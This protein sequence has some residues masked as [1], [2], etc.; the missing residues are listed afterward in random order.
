M[1]IRQNSFQKIP[2][3]RL[4]RSTNLSERIN[5]F[6]TNTPEGVPFIRRLLISES[7][8]LLTRADKHYK[9]SLSK[10]SKPPVLEKA[11]IIDTICGDGQAIVPPPL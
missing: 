10:M 6:P 3:N 9:K 7:T 11:L 4:R 5:P 8:I 2:F 1:E